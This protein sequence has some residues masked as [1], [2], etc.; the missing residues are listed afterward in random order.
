[1]EPVYMI[2]GHSAGVAAVMALRSAKP[3]QQIDMQALES[4][5][6]SQGQVLHKSQRRKI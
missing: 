3:V 4:K 2:M 1:M 6:R 5:L